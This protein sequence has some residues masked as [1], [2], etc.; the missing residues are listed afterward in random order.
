MRGYNTNVPYIN[1]TPIKILKHTP[2][3]RDSLLIPYLE[4][5]LQSFQITR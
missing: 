2:P 1:G 5:A 4:K 3:N